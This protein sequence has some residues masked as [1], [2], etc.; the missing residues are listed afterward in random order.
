MFQGQNTKLFMVS[1]IFLV[2]PN[3]ELLDPNMELN[4]L[5]KGTQGTQPKVF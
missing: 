4:A 2:Y 5:N 3:V 1:L